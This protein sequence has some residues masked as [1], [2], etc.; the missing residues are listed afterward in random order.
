MTNT[1]Y[2]IA[3]VNIG[4]ILGPMDGEIMYGFAS[5]LDEINALADNYE[6]FVWRLQTD[7]GDATA[8]RPYEDD[9]MLINMSV[10]ETIDALWDYTY[11]SAHVELLK[12]R[13]NWFEHMKD[14]HMCLWWV[15]A[16]TIPTT[17][18][19][20]QRLAYINQH[21]ATPYAFTFKKRFTAEE[22]Q[23]YQVVE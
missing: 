5:R 19:A 8:L 11:K 6:G 21:G 4:R 3:Q 18:E 16:G 17:D 20:K 10:W 23:A 12:G 14:M 2:H 13:W 7:D 1:E 9:R 22:L 15:P